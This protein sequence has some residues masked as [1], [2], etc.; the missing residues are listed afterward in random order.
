MREAGFHVF[1]VGL[2]YCLAEGDLELLSLPSLPNKRV[3]VF[4]WFGDGTEAL[5][6]VGKRSTN[7]ALSIP[8]HLADRD[9]SWA[10]MSHSAG[11]HHF[12]PSHF[13]LE[14]D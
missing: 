13:L 4:M 11:C 12:L 1:R 9:R 6:M 8:G 5:G 10:G 3:L 2:K 7:K 14:K